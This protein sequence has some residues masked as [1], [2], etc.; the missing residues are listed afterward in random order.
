MREAEELIFFSY[1]GQEDTRAQ[2]DKGIL[3]LFFQI[4]FFLRGY[5]FKLNL[6]PVNDVSWWVG[7]KRQNFIESF[8]GNFTFG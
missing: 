3:V 5:L 2:S 1:L 7:V 4:L 8:Y 6:Y